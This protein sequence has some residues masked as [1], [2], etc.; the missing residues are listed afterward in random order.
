MMRETKKERSR[1]AKEHGAKK[2]REEM[3]GFRRRM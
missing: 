1:D 2:N 3:I